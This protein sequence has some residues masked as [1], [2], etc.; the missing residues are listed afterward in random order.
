LL[1]RAAGERQDLERRIELTEQEL[2]RRA[3][4]VAGS[5]F[6]LEEML[7]IAIRAVEECRPRP[8]QYLGRIT[9]GLAAMGVKVVGQFRRFIQEQ[10]EASKEKRELRNRESLELERLHQTCELLTDHWRGT[11]P[12]EAGRL[13]AAGRCAQ[14]RQHLAAQA[15]PPVHADWEAFVR[16]QTI[17]WARKHWFLSNTLSALKDV[18]TLGGVAVVALDLT[19]AG[20]AG[21]GII[22]AAGAGSVGA[23]LIVEL[24]D[25][26][27]MGSVLREADAEW[28]TKR[29]LQ[30]AEHLE[31]HFADPLFLSLWKERARRLEAAP[32]DRCFGACDALQALSQPQ[33]DSWPAAEL[34]VGH[35]EMV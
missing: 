16:Q 6:P 30:I 7:T 4:F 9:G 26:L 3:E 35:G 12:E 21:L 34:P 2:M 10:K 28:R 29:S 33:A 11:Y 15:L 8:L 19:V 31:R 5:E 32:L 23:G 24:F 18:L 20:G 14:A 13:L 27:R 25:R 17:T 22:T 1:E